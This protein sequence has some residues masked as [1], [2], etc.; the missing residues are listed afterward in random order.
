MAA[1][2]HKQHFYDEGKNQP[3]ISYLNYLPVSLDSRSML[4]VSRAE[5]RFRFAWMEGSA[6]V[7][8]VVVP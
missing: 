1:M 8:T 3:M 7:H 2:M 5:R 6:I 4:L